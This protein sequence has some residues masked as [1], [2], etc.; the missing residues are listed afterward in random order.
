MAVENLNSMFD[1]SASLSNPKY[2]SR[3]PN[4]INNNDRWFDE[5]CK[6]L[7]KKWRNLSSQNYRDPEN[8]SLQKYT[9][10]KEGTACQKSAQCTSRI[11]RI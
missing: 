11:H 8:L 5:E 2:S 1:L 4:K 3:Q 7:R 9:M 6:N 10:E